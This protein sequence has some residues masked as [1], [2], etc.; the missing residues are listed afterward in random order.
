MFQKKNE[1]FEDYEKRMMRR[2]DILFP[3]MKDKEADKTKKPK[4]LPLGKSIY[5]EEDT[6]TPDREADKTGESGLDAIDDFKPKKNTHEKDDK[7]P[8][9]KSRKERTPE[10]NEEF[11]NEF[12]PSMKNTGKKSETNVIPE[13]R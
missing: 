10:E 8:A 4:I 7:K 12:Y 11:L 2:A 9:Y 5:D 13:S 1:S 6:K 3:S